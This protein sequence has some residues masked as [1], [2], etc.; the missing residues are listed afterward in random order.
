MGVYEVLD[1]SHGY[2]RLWE[3]RWCPDSEMIRLVRECK[4]FA[5]VRDDWRDKEDWT[6]RWCRNK[7]NEG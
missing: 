1:F 6:V 5:G 7:E 2:T 4:K 3:L